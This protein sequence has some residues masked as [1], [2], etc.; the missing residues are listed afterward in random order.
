MTFDVGQQLWIKHTHI[1]IKYILKSPETDINILVATFLKI[2][3]RCDKNTLFFRVKLSQKL[4]RQH[5]KARLFTSTQC[6]DNANAQSV[7]V[8]ERE[9]VK[10]Q[11]R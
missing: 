1:L 3:H 9:S 10:I 4:Y 7:C 6:G 11:S 5:K 8:W 2:K